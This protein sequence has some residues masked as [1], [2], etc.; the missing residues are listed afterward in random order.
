MTGHIVQ[1]L[2][3]PQEIQHEAVGI[4]ALANAIHISAQ[5]D[6]DAAGGYLNRVKKYRANVAAFCNPNIQKWHAGWKSALADKEALDAPG[7][8]AEEILKKKRSAWFLEQKRI[9]DEAE[10]VARVRLEAEA[11][12]ERVAK[13]RELDEAGA[14][15]AA[16][17]LLRAPP[18]V[19]V[20]PKAAPVAGGVAH[21]RRTPSYVIE[22][23]TK[24][25]DKYWIL[26]DRMI[27]DEVDAM[28]DAVDIPGIR[29]VWRE[30][31]VERGAR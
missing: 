30:Q 7:N 6:Y 20:V 31:V 19:V 29:F 24:I 16:E 26:N 4:V 23:A 1:T 2:P 11:L 25:P 15:K 17:A 22:D 13:A 18:P 5:E 21:V 8:Q 27:Q 10:R 12:A 28:K 14:K 9:A 3:V